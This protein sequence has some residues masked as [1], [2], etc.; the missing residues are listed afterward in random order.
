MNNFYQNPTTFG[1]PQSSL[2]TLPTTLD[3]INPAYY[4]Q[5]AS[6]VA[7]NGGRLASI[8]GIVLYDTLRI[9]AGILPGRDFGFFQNSVG[10][11]Q[12]LFITPG[13]T[14]VKQ[15]IDISPWVDAGKLA[16]GYEALIW[17]LE[18]QIHTVAALDETIQTTGNAVNLTLDPGL[19]SG[20]AATDPI[21]Q[22]NVMRAFQEGLYFRLFV[23]NTEFEHGPTWRFPTC[24]GT[25]PDI[26]LA[27][28]VV[29]PAADGA[30][31][32]SLGWAYQMPVMRYIP[33]LTKFG[34]KMSVQNQFDLTTAGPVRVV[35]ALTGI[36][37]QPVTG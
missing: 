31:V 27:G 28:T 25:S 33:S 20:E 1:F 6:F 12:G 13:I 24:Y 34:V 11:P 3:Q 19:I 22:A 14:Y 30:L 5:I 8:C 15:E 7:R 37:V 17:G 21:K 2:G 23:N 9:N 35:V 18:V 36:G 10:V 4:N 32:N 16:Q 26:A 29:A